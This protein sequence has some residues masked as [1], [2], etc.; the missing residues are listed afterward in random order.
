[1]S[2]FLLFNFYIQNFLSVTISFLGIICIGIAFVLINRGYFHL[3]KIFTFAVCLGS[4]FMSASSEGR[5]AGYQYFWFPFLVSIFIFFSPSEKRSIAF[6]VLMIFSAVV[7]L[8]LTDYSLF[9]NKNAKE[10]TMLEINSTIYFFTSGGL[11]F[12]Y[13]YYM[14][15][16]NLQTEKKLKLINE[17]LIISNENLKKTN[18]ELDSFVYKASHDLR[19]PLVSL[20]GLIEITKNEKDFD[21]VKQYLLL[22]EKSVKKLDSLILDILDISKNARLDIEVNEIDFNLLFEDVFSNYN[23][24]ED[25]SKIEKIVNI[26]AK[27]VFYSDTKRLNMVFNN[28]VSNSI[29][30]SDI[31]KPK[32]YIKIDIEIYPSHAYIKVKD[33]G[34][35]I[36]KEHF[37]K[38]FDM[39]FR[40]NE[41]NTGSGLGLY[42]VKE[43]LQKLK[44]NVQMSSEYMEWTEFQLMIPNKKPTIQLEV[45]S[46]Q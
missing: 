42:I 21:K 8:E 40:A 26:N 19:S 2:I 20:L 31:S 4:L 43:T 16:N 27:G 24:L 18:S 22:K 32:P 46:N 6:V 17:A 1:M 33:N 29:R 9:I 37:Q 14:V 35:G 11:I 23:Y 7:A 25:Y 10:N 5:D 12:F 39:Y 41:R 45:I 13:F 28:L 3:S 15:S 36:R 34:Q 44:G 30:Y 38:I